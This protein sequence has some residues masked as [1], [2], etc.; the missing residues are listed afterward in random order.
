MR[1][2]DYIVEKLVKNGVKHV[3]MLTG[4]GAMFL[5]DAFGL[6][7]RIQYVC[8]QHEQAS[9]MAAEG[10]ARITGRMAV[11]CV[12]SGPG[13]T[14]ALTGVLGQWMDSIPVLYL[15]G[16]VRFATTVA[17]TNLPLRQLGDQEASIVDIVRPI[18]KYAVMVTDPQTIRYHL[19]KAIHLAVSGRPGPVWLDIPLDIQSSIVE[20]ANLKPYN[21]EEATVPSNPELLEDQVDT[22]I[23]RLTASVR[24]VILAGA[25]I[26]LAGAAEDFYYTAERLGI[27]VQVAWNAIDLFPSDHPL[28]SGRP[29]TLGQRGANFIFQNSDLLLSL[30]CRLN[31]R[32]IGYTFSAVAREA[33]KIS[34]DIDPAELK[35]PTL[36]IDLPI[37]ADAGEFIRRLNIKLKSKKIP[38]KT[39]WISWC[40]ERIQRYPLILPEFLDENKPV[41][42]YVFS[43]VLSRCLNTDDVVVSS[44]GSSCVMPIQTMQ[45]KRGQRHIVNSG[46]AAMGY[47]LPAAIGACFARGGKRVICLEGD[48]S[49]QMNIQELETVCYHRLPLKIFVFNNGAY[50]SMRITQNNFFNGRLVGESATSGVGFPDFVKLAEAYGIQTFRIKNNGDLERTINQVLET[51]GPVLCDVIM[52][53][54]QVFTP[55]SASRQMPDGQM[56]SSPLEDMYPFLNEDE[57]ISNMIIPRW[58][59]E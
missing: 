13:G 29:S 44:N 49:I 3:F 7:K 51:E 31:V 2:C 43:D 21:P 32:Q 23:E 41:N 37:N 46:N 36:K 39:A 40:K 45:I 38:E 35:K 25:G 53:P 33:Y 55:R 47:G 1:A 48:G 11:V 12:T 59:T 17:S 10:Y 26:R 56:V 8:N 5:D 50:L 18:T 58:K 42:P 27:P 16:Q 6:E 20:E 15:S 24:P 14:N 57:F 19:E 34:V 52:D 28:Y 4:G 30:G 22:V 9:A 54:N